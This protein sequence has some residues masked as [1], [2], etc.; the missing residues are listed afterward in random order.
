MVTIW[1]NGERKFK[2]NL[3][4]T[5]GKMSEKMDLKKT[6]DVFVFKTPNRGKGGSNHE[7]IKVWFVQKSNIN[8][9]LFKLKGECTGRWG[10]YSF[11]DPI[12]N[13]YRK[14]YSSL[15]FFHKNKEIMLKLFHRIESAHNIPNIFQLAMKSLM[16]NFF[17]TLF[18]PLP[19]RFLG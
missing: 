15:C 9:F 19:L 18:S 10:K 11:K 16:G 3:K 8:F 12:S 4:K 6:F 7:S 14:C 13:V 1:G 5:R 2:L 17:L